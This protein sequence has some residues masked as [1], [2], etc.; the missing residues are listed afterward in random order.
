M[1]SAVET[2]KW[3]S[4]VAFFGPPSAGKTTLAYALGCS[5]FGATTVEN[6]SHPAFTEV[7]G[8]DSKTIDDVRALIAL[9]KTRPMRG[10]RRFILIDEAHGLLSNAQAAGALLGALE[11]PPASTTWILCSMEPDKFRGST[12]GNAMLS[13]LTKFNLSKPTEAD[14]MAQAM[15]IAKGEKMAKFL[16]KAVL[17]QVVQASEGMMREVANLLQCLQLE[18]S[19][20]EPGTKFT[21]ADVSG[22]LSS[23]TSADQDET[24]AAFLTAV[25]AGQLSTAAT[26]ALNVTEG[27]RFI[28]AMLQAH[29]TAMNIRFMNG[30]RHPRLQ[31]YGAAK[32]LT[33]FL[34]ATKPA[35]AVM[36]KI[37]HEL[38]ELKARSQAFAVPE[39][40]LFTDFLYRVAA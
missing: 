21:A 9:S 22:V 15:R 37:H 29:W 12:V 16:D 10:N 26:H 38:C 31:V 34:M 17:A 40:F 32:T 20:L 23:A 8:T 3:P 36:L 13:R 11:R 33:A 39:Q 24:I 18:S 14:L 30:E 7:V 2:G 4:A 35:S 6:N 5:A 28:N 25:Y 27:F 1:T 19:S